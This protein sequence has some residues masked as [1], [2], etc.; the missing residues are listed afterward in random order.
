[1][2]GRNLRPRPPVTPT[3]PMS[4]MDANPDFHVQ[5]KPDPGAD[6]QSGYCSLFS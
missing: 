3:Q 1:M 5:K 6:I 4:G 2:P